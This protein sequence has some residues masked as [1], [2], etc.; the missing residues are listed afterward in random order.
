M[1]LAPLKDASVT[2]IDAVPP[3]FALRVPSNPAYGF[4]ILLHESR[5][6]LHFAA[7]THPTSLGLPINSATATP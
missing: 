4:V 2:K 7:T 3:K 5:C 6:V 1:P